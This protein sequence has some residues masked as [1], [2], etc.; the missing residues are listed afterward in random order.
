MQQVEEEDH[1]EHKEAQIKEERR[2]EMQ[3]LVAARMANIFTK[4]AQSIVGCHS[5]I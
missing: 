5:I 1:S 4:T 3:S 2:K